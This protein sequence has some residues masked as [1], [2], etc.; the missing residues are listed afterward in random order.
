M[1]TRII[2]PDLGATGSDVRVAGWL[3]RE[4]DRVTAGKPLF[5]LETDKATH[6]VEAFR[7]GYLRKILA[8]VDSQVEIGAVVALLTDSLDEALDQPP[9]REVPPPDIAASVA[10]DERPKPLPR[11][12]RILASPL[13]KRLARERGMDLASVPGSGRGGPIHKRHV[14]QALAAGMG[15]ETVNAPLA[16]RRVPLSPMRRAIAQRTQYSKSQVPH[17]Y[18]GVTIDLTDALT[19]RGQ[20]Q[21]PEVCRGRPVPTVNDFILFATAQALRQTPDLNASFHGDELVCFDEIAI[22]VAMAVGD[23]VVVPVLRGADQLD[24]WSLAAATIVL[25]SRAQAGRLA[26][27]ELA[28]GALTVSNLGMHGLDRFV[29]VINPPQAAVLAIGTARP[30][31]A[32]H[33]GQLAIRTLLDATLSLDHRVADG[34]AAARFLGELRQHLENPNSLMNHDEDETHS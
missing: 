31:P 27:S 11:S 3:A 7:T 5:T 9:E 25:R 34:V 28:G 2:V 30:R 22:G 33:E 4:G 26:V 21:S 10:T 18:A 20:L 19:L 23:G 14:L 6:D 17:F 32:V 13:A 1:I 29:A 12:G 15:N 24:L 16:G 8:P